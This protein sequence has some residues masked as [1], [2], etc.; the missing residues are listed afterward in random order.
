MQR[1]NESCVGCKSRTNRFF[2][3]LSASAL[4]AFEALGVTTNYPGRSLLFTEGQPSRGIFVLCHGRV[5][6]FTCSRDGTVILRIAGPG[7]GLGLSASVSGKP[8][9]LTAESIEPCQVKF[10]KQ[11]DF[12]SLLRQHNDACLRAIQQ[13]SDKYNSA[14]R[15]IRALGLSHS[16]AEK[17]GRLLVEYSSRNG[18]ADNQQPRLKLG[19]THEE[20]SEMIGTSRETVTRLL[21]QLKKRRIVEVKG[22]TLLICNRAALEA[23]A[24]E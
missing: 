17:L 21:A 15:E 12:R 22:A 8:Y 1:G 14:C 6:L 23:L 9:S 11:E 2:C 3:N 19:F 4:H 16:A 7:E 10:V 18:Q 20:I 24:A 13:L 5:K